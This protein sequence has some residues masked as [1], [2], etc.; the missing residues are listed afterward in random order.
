MNKKYE[1]MAKDLS[2]AGRFGDTRILHVNEAE[3]AGLGSLLPS[4]ELPTNPE[5][6]QPEAAILT[7]LIIGAIIGA[8]SGGITAEQKGIP[9][10]QGILQGAGIGMATG[11]LTGGLGAATGSGAQAGTQAGT[12]AALDASANTLV[13]TSMQGA[14][15]AAGAEGVKTAAVETG[16]TAALEAAGKTSEQA[17]MDAAFKQAA[18][19]GVEEMI[20]TA[21][22]ESANQASGVIP[23]GQTG[24]DIAGASASGVASGGPAEFA[25]DPLTVNAGEMSGA[26]PN[27]PPA[28]GPG[29]IDQVASEFTQEGLADSVS[30]EALKEYAGNPLNYIAPVMATEALLPSEYDEEDYLAGY[31]GPYDK[32]WSSSPGISWAANNGGEVK[33]RSAQPETPIQRVV[34]L[35]E[36]AKRITD[37]TL[38]GKY[39]PLSD[40]PV[41]IKI[42]P[43]VNPSGMHRFGVTLPFNQGGLASLR[44]R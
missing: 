14:I 34:R 35:A 7:S 16:K 4:G 44:R 15:Q 28:E 10:W 21:P 42:R 19:A 24:A 6:G 41:R 13:D 26:P 9:L 39:N 33:K 18:E 43:S 27:T 37:P 31:E 8:T 17:A 32:T 30:R 25:G 40:E 38:P 11:A 20:V 29:F 3:L 12:Q 22:I 23:F 36:L 2:E 5:T 1:K